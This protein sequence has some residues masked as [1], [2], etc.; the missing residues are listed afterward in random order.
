MISAPTGDSQKLTG[1]IIAIV[2]RGPIPGRTP[3]AVPM[4]QPNRHKPIFCQVSAMPKPIAILD[5]MSGMSERRPQCD[6]DAQREHEDPDIGEN[7][8]EAEQ[9]E[10][11]RADL[12]AGETGEQDA[13][14]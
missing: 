6:L 13:D 3:I 4:M 7:Q 12:S 8:D 2:V 9:Q 5:R 1:R 11:N 10:R 14:Q